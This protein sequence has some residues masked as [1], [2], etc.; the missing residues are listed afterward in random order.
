MVIPLAGV[1]RHDTRLLQKILLDV[2]AFDGAAFVKADVDVFAEAGRVVIAHSFGVAERC[3]FTINYSTHVSAG[4]VD[5]NSFIELFTFEDGI[6]FKDL[7]L[8]PRMFSTD[9]RQILQN[10][11]SAFGFSCSRFSAV[12]FSVIKA[13]GKFSHYTTYILLLQNTQL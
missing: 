3:E 10:K 5:S 12:L 13:K 8:D 7:L 1:L 6:S 2:G 4:K 11:L 9:S